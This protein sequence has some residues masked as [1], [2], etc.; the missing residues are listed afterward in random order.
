M[1][2]RHPVSFIYVFS[3][4]TLWLFFAIPPAQASDSLHFQFTITDFYDPLLSPA[5]NKEQLDTLGAEKISITSKYE[6]IRDTSGTIIK[7][8]FRNECM[9]SMCFSGKTVEEKQYQ[10]H[11]ATSIRY[12]TQQR[13]ISFELPPPVN[14]PE[15]AYKI[16]SVT[17]TTPF[18]TAHILYNTSINPIDYFNN[19]ENS[20]LSLINPNP[21]SR[22]PHI[23][24]DS[25]KGLIAQLALLNQPI[26]PSKAPQTFSDQEKK[27]IFLQRHLSHYGGEH[28]IVVPATLP[29]WYQI[30]STAQ[31][32]REAK[33]LL[34]NDQGME[35]IVLTGDISGSLE[36]ES[37]GTYYRDE[38][39]L[40]NN[41]KLTHIYL[42]PIHIPDYGCDFIYGIT[43]FEDGTE[44][45]YF[46]QNFTLAEKFDDELIR[47]KKVFV[48]PA[49]LTALDEYEAQRE[50]YFH[51]QK[52]Y[53]SIADRM[54]ACKR[55]ITDAKRLLA[56]P[57]E[58]LEQEFEQY[59]QIIKDADDNK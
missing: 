19:R 43:F 36:N 10:Y 25:Y 16:Q 34:V 37:Q 33:G 3:L 11:E 26:T 15:L 9:T 1:H 22:F 13:Q 31:D 18:S 8:V 23:Y 39:W 50:Q 29:S 32:Q 58:Q 51:S 7:R 44:E 28:K 57:K 52:A 2:K 27:E 55:M 56:S 53:P 12:N 35:A 59:K 14:T 42:N 20:R 47:Q 6:P 5:Q 48:T 49:D 17:I 30:N 45:R 24:L 38:R 4:L 54:P 46:A 41:G 21:D 40:R